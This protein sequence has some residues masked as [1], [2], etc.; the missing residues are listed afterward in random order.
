MQLESMQPLAPSFFHMMLLDKIFSKDVQKEGEKSTDD[1]IQDLIKALHGNVTT[2]MDFMIYNISL[3]ARKHPEIV[4]FFE[5][6]LKNA[7]YNEIE[8]EFIIKPNELIQELMINE[9]L[10]E[11]GG[12][13]VAEE[14]EVLLRTFGFRGPSEIGFFEPFMFIFF[15]FFSFS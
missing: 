14:I 2:E 3:V 4:E 13:E 15:I 7:K 9:N 10:R 8:D 5:N 12:K 11:N 1:Y 6:A